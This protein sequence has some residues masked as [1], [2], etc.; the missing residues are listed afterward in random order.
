MDY[1]IARMFSLECPHIS[2]H[3]EPSGPPLPWCL[4]CLAC[5][6]VATACGAG[7]AAGC[8]RRAYSYVAGVVVAAVAATVFAGH[9]RMLRLRLL[10]L[11]LWSVCSVSGNGTQR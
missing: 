7:C 6:V 3:D 8:A 11:L 4:V 5:G 9:G 1:N 10:L 2:V